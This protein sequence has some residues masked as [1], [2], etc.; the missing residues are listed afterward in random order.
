MK[1]MSQFWDQKPCETYTSSA[2]NLGNR[3]SVAWT[4]LIY[5]ERI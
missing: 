3:C 1:L 5:Y 4:D 2:W